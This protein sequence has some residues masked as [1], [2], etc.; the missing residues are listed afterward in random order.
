MAQKY[1]VF[2]MDKNMD[3]IQ[4]L[5]VK[6]IYDLPYFEELGTLFHT[7]AKIASVGAIL[8]GLF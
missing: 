1:R 2:Q 7:H 4:M 6:T 3:F 8:I 5:K